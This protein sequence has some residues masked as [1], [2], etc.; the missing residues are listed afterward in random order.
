MKCGTCRSVARSTTYTVTSLVHEPGRRAGVWMSD[1]KQY[2]T[3][4]DARLVA[5]ELRAVCGVMVNE[6]QAIFGRHPEA[7]P[8]WW[9]E[10]FAG[11]EAVIHEVAS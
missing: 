10:E 1:P 2:W 7:G 5:G 9:C 4:K 3:E 11:R 8:C 6:V